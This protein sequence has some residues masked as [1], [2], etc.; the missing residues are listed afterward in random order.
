MQFPAV[1]TVTTSPLTVQ[2]LGVSV[3]RLV[4][5]DPDPPVTDAENSLTAPYVNAVWLVATVKDACSSFTAAPAL[6][7]PLPHTFWNVV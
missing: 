5:P 6:S 3:V 2:T 7:R 1:S 4:A